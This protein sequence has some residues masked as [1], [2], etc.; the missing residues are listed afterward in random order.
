MSDETEARLTEIRVRVESDKDKNW[1]PQFRSR[2]H[3][4]E[5]RAWLLEL[6]AEL[7]KQL[8]V[9]YCSYCG[10]DFPLDDS[11]A[12]VTEHIRTCEHH[13]MRRVERE[14]LA[15]RERVR[16]LEYQI[17]NNPNRYSW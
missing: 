7:Q 6:V 8:R 15:I 2:P 9:T 10:A 12:A 16:E 11:A 14:N 4:E 1:A 13:P 3:V 17:E 5:D